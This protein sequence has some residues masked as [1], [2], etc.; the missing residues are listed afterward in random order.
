MR[1]SSVAVTLLLTLSCVP[2]AE[3]PQGQTAAYQGVETADQ[4]FSLEQSRALR[5]R[6]EPSF[7]S[8]TEG[9]DLSRYVYL[10]PSEFWA[11]IV[12]TEGA[13]TRELTTG[14]QDAVAGFPVTVEA[15]ETTVSEY[16]SDSPTD[17]AIV[18]HDGRIMFEDYPRMRAKDKHIWFSVSKTFVSTA[19]AILEDRGEIDAD[20]PIDTYLTD[21][22]GTAWSGIP[23]VDI[24]D[25]AS[26]IDCPEVKSDPDSCFWEFYDAFGWP[27]T[28]RV[29]DDA[30]AT[31]P[32]MGTL[33]PSGQIF[34]YTSVNTEVLNRLVEVVSG[35]RFS[36]F[37][38]REIWQPAGPESDALIGTTANGA[39][40]SA[41]GVSSNL[42]DLAR[43]GMLFTDA[44]RAEGDPAISDAYMEKIQVSG[45]PELT[46]ANPDTWPRTAL[47]DGSFRHNTYQW[48][49]VTTD[50]HFFKSGFG[51]QGLYVAPDLNLVVAWFGT[52]D[53]RGS[54]E[55]L[56]IARQLATSGIF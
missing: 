2:S 55:M 39:A 37:V 25:M 21:L 16:V 4:V 41:G 30:M 13:Y 6:F 35:E 20:A 31:V 8:W 48:D 17:G 32:A 15:G 29:Q 49:I 28:S 23:V 46:L 51:G 47:E 3:P 44:I 7:A 42:R 27:V 53:E 36:D 11:Q 50:G 22:S 14:S 43:F 26:G 24:L 1:T 56:G 19:V 33:R 38:E 5:D 9:G 40:F 45:R 52:Q 10:N 12:L 54:T 18:V 34:D